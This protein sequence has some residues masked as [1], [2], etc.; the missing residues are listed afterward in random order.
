M[1][2]RTAEETARREHTLAVDMQ[3]ATPLP[4]TPALS[5]RL[6]LLEKA[7]RETDDDQQYKPRHAALKCTTDVQALTRSRHVCMFLAH[8]CITPYM[9]INMTDRN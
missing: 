3:V 2:P 9:V 7:S 1:P 5:D 6:R 8:T 4:S